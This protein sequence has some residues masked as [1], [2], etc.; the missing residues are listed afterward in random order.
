[1]LLSLIDFSL[2]GG[3]I[4]IA[5]VLGIQNIKMRALGTAAQEE[6]RRLCMVLD[7]LPG[8]AFMCLVDEHCTMTY[9][10]PR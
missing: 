10:S 8:M 7:R 5:V 2:L 9:V 6:R 1:M 3:L 4:A